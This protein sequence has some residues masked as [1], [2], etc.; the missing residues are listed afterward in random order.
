MCVWGGGGGLRRKAARISTGI[1]TFPL[2]NW[3]QLD[4]QGVGVD[5]SDPKG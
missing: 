1:K 2:A 5:G 3:R 4:K